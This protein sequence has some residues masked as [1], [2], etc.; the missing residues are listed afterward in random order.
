M[1]LVFSPAQGGT[2]AGSPAGTPSSA[3]LGRHYSPPQL[4]LTWVALAGQ[5]TVTYTGFIM[6]YLPLTRSSFLLTCLLPLPPLVVSDLLLG[7]ET[8][9]TWTL[10]A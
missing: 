3:N 6:A 4:Q 1:P 9:G 7:W 10:G 5:L 2:S 8:T